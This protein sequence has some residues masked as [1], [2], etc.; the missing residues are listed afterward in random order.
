MDDLTTGLGELGKLFSEDELENYGT[1]LWKIKVATA[2]V[3]IESGSNSIKA[4]DPPEVFT[5]IHTTLVEGANACLKSTK[6]LTAGVDNNDIE[7]FSAAS[8]YVRVCGEKIN[9]ANAQL[10]ALKQQ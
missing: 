10:D 1:D 3:L 8:Q 7:E 2:I 9:E 6:H 4:L 5:D